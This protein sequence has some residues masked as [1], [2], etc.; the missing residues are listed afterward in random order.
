MLIYLYSVLFAALAVVYCEVLTAPGNILGWWD[1][2]VHTLIKNE[3]ILKPL[4]DCPYCF[5]GQLSLWSYLIIIY[6]T[7]A[8]YDWMEHILFVGLTIFII[9]IYKQIWN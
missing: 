9:H 6:R 1:K 8:T 5:G 7:G 4:G 3:S 2:L